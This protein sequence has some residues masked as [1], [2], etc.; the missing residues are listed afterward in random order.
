MDQEDSL[1]LYMG[2]E[3]DLACP[4]TDVMCEYAGIHQGSL[5]GALGSLEE[6]FLIEKTDSFEG[7]DTWKVFTAPPSYYK[8]DFMNKKVATR[9]ALKN[10]PLSRF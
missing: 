2:R 5:N 8:R 4:D 1:D 9:Y 6:H 10:Y 3:W 7:Q